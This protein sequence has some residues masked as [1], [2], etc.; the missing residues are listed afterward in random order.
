MSR[1]GVAH[2]PATPR[3]SRHSASGEQTWVID[4]TTTPAVRSAE[5]LAVKR[6][7]AGNLLVAVASLVWAYDLIYIATHVTGS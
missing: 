4:L 7:R 5:V 1:T 2:H 3:S 6:S